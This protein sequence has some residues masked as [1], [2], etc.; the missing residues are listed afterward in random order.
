VPFG[1]DVGFYIHNHDD[2]GR[3]VY[4]SNNSNNWHAAPQN[5]SPVL[6][7][8]PGYAQ[9]TEGTLKAGG[10]ITIDYEL[11][12]LLCLAVDSS[13][14]LPSSQAAT[15]Y[16]RF[17]NLGAA[18]TGV[19]LTGLPYG[20]PGTLNGKTGTLQVAPTIQVPVGANQIEIYFQGNN[21]N[22]YDSNNSNNYFFSISP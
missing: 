17:P 10:T 16:Y 18:F 20:V 12:R 5:P 3:G 1:N 9:V 22:C 4:D 15:L 2:S 21:S 6:H 19:S 14:R 11:K 13:D 7:F 8:K